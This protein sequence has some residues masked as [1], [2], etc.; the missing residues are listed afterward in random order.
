MGDNVNIKTEFPKILSDQ[1]RVD[2][3]PWLTEKSEYSLKAL[4]ELRKDLLKIESKIDEQTLHYIQT[5][6]QEALYDI[7]K[8]Y[9]FSLGGDFNPNDASL[10]YEELDDGFEELK[11]RYG[12]LDKTNKQKK[13][14][15]REIFLQKLNEYLDM[16]QFPGRSMLQELFENNLSLLNDKNINS[17]L[18]TKIEKDLYRVANSELEWDKFITETKNL[19][20]FLSKNNY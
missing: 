17:R 19:L 2:M 14:E 11:V 8:I 5:D 10:I 3:G 18:F 13:T 15:K 12:I 9:C 20:I 7:T 6:L 16:D 4:L 1:Y